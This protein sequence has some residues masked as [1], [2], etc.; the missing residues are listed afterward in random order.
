MR[1]GVAGC[2][3]GVRCVGLGRVAGSLY[4]RLGGEKGQSK[5]GAD[6]QPPAR[7]TQKT[8]SVPLALA[9]PTPRLLLLPCYPDH[10]S[11]RSLGHWPPQACRS[12]RQMPMPPPPPT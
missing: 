3:G 8:S 6:P 2:L 11:I 9:P 12:T 1:D 5:I 4:L 10:P 7:A